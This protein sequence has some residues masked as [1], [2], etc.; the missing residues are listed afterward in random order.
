MVTLS[1]QLQRE[2]LLKAELRL[3]QAHVLRQRQQLGATGSV[4]GQSVLRRGNVGLESEAA[5][6]LAP[7]EGTASTAGGV[8]TV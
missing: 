5:R 8:S 3:T 2:D 7:G 1:W 6:G 4:Q